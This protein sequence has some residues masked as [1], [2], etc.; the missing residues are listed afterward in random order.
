M[1]ELIF[2]FCSQ[3]AIHIPLKT[4]L[5][6]D[7]NEWEQSQKKKC[8]EQHNK[9]DI[10]F[11]PSSFFRWY[12]YCSTNFQILRSLWMRLIDT[13]WLTDWLSCGRFI[14]SILFLSST[15]C[16]FLT[17]HEVGFYVNFVLIIPLRY[18]R[19]RSNK[20]AAI[21]YKH[22]ILSYQLLLWCM[23]KTKIKTIDDDV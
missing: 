12:Y 5:F 7:T 23:V 13:G 2:V 18:N 22:H 10:H 14:H 1:Q 15:K 6:V 21:K 20:R 19:R 9:I 16:H 8:V 4:Q 17:I 3:F 11:R